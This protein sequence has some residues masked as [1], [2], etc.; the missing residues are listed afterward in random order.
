MFL[1]PLLLFYTVHEIFSHCGYTYVDVPMVEITT[2]T[3]GCGYVSVSW[4]VPDSNK[5]PVR[6]YTVTLSSTMD[7]LTS[8]MTSHKQHTF[9]GLSFNTLFNVTVFSHIAHVLLSGSVT[10]SVRTKDREGVYTHMYV[11]IIGLRT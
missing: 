11:V 7:E 4:T 8:V 6:S 2:A 9:N 1:L 3:G 5:C 10:T